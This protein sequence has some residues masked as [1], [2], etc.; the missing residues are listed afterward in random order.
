L[1]AGIHACRSK[2]TWRTQVVMYMN[3]RICILIASIYATISIIIF[4]YAMGVAHGSPII[5]EFLFLLLAP[6]RIIDSF[7]RMDINIYGVFVVQFIS[8]FF[9]CALIKILLLAKLK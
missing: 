7:L 9:A 1:A 2:R 8:C 5:G 3:S 4:N 6:S